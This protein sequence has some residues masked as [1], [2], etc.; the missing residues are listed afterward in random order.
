MRIVKSFEE[1]L[2]TGVVKKVSIDKSRAKN[3]FLESERKFKLLQKKIEKMGI[4]HEIANDY[5]EDSYNILIFLIRAKMLEKG[6]TSSGQ[7]AH[8]A[9][10]AYSRKLNF[11]DA[12]IQLLNQLRYFRNGILYYGKRFDKEYAEKIIKFAKKKFKEMTSSAP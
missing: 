8:E 1:F 3:L 9:E 11:N 4:D 10:V 12:E 2:K 6:Y 7:G 5:I